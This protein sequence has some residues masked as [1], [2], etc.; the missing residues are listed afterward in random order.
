MRLTDG[1]EH[2]ELIGGE[3]AALLPD[4]AVGA[5]SLGLRIAD[6]VVGDLVGALRRD[7][8]GIVTL[9]VIAA[10]RHDVHARLGGDALQGG[11]A[12]VHV[13][14]TAVDDAAHA[15]F[16]GCPRLRN[17]QVDVVGKVRWRRRPLLRGKS[18]GQRVVNREVLVEQNCSRREGRRRHVLEQSTDDGALG[19]GRRPGAGPCL[20]WR[21]LE[22]RVAAETKGQAESAAEACGRDQKR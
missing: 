13:R 19:K 2:F 6:E 15:V 11:E 22:V 1:G 8:R 21:A 3:R 16:A 7:L 17:H 9:H 20:P 4:L 12:A 10:A 18:V 14:V 5:Q